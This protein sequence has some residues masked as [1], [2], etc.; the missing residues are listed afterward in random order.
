LPV[1][2]PVPGIAG[3]LVATGFSGHGFALS[4]LVGDLLARLALGSGLTFRH[5]GPSAHAKM[6]ECKT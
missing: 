3:L 4:P 5:F 6:S 1:I 2:G